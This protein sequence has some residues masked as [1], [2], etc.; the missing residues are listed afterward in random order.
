MVL[1]V[2]RRAAAI[3]VTC[4]LS[5]CGPSAVGV[6]KAP[7]FTE[8]VTGA[9]P[10]LMSSK[11]VDSPAGYMAGKGEKALG[12]FSEI[13]QMRLPALAARDGFVPKLVTVSDPNFTKGGYKKV[14]ALPGTAPPRHFL[15]IQP[16][17]MQTQCSATC[18]STINVITSVYDTKLEKEVWQASIDVSE[19]SGLHEY[20]N[21]DVEAFWTLLVEQL[22]ES[23]LL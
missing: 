23:R 20:D 2:F 1:H 9:T 15:I 8:K 16:Y 11:L 12:K 10:V 17:R 4:L 5:A 7:D 14:A 22:K 21:G 19:K 3:L 18:R 13:V 6:V